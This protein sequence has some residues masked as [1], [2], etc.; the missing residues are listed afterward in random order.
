MD[1]IDTSPLNFQLQKLFESA[2]SEKS[3]AK[4]AAKAKAKAKVRSAT[5]FNAIDAPTRLPKKRY[6]D[7]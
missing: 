3:K 6:T 2:M 4:R 7:E 1:L 5:R